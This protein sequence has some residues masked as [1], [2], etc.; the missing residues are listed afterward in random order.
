VK[1]VV[2]TQTQTC[3]RLSWKTVEYG[4]CDVTMFISFLQRDGTT[5]N[6]T[7]PASDQVFRDCTVT[8]KSIAVHYK[9]LLWE[10]RTE[11][12]ANG[13][14]NGLSATYKYTELKIIKETPCEG[15]CYKFKTSKKVALRHSIRVKKHSERKAA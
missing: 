15:E 8:V 5:I 2:F 12:L 6:V 13:E 11:K 14:R 1:N 4:F 7:A 10:K 9:A 3:P